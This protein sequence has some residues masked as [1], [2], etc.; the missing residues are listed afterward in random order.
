MPRPNLEP[1]YLA[2]L[3]AKA[4]DL[5]SNPPEGMGAISYFSGTARQRFKEVIMSGDWLHDQL[6]EE[7]IPEDEIEKICFAHGQ[8]CFASIDPWQVAQDAF[9]KWVDGKPDKPGARLAE[10]VCEQVFGKNE[11]LAQ[12][13]KELYDKY[14]VFLD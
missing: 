8:R 5:L 10:E 4:E 13:R 1:E 9:L 12:K 11:V 3:E 7:N 6:A 14:S 2:E